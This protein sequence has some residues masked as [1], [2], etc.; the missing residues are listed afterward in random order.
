[1]NNYIFPA[2]SKVVTDNKGHFPIPDVAH[3]RNAVAQVAKYDA[4]PEWYKGAMTLP[5]FKKYVQGKVKKTFPSIDVTI[6]KVD[7]AATDADGGRGDD[8]HTRF[9]AFCE[10]RKKGAITDSDDSSDKTLEEIRKWANSSH[11]YLSRR[12]D[13]ARGYAEGLDVAKE[14]ILEILEK[15]SQEE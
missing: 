11:S 6:D 10:Q 1:M 7:D 2:K 13:Y 12:T 4:L 14:I 9:K 15:K 3:G 8:L 5:E